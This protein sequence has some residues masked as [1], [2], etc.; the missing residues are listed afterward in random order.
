MARYP[1]LHKLHEMMQQKIYRYLGW[2]YENLAVSLY[3]A[4]NSVKFKKEF[5]SKVDK[6]RPVII[7]FADYQ[8]VDLALN[9]LKSTENVG[10]Q[11]LVTIALDEKLYKTLA[12][13]MLVNV[14]LFSCY[15]RSSGLGLVWK[16]R[17]IVIS[18]LLDEGYDIIHSDLDAIWLK[19]LIPEYLNTHSGLDLI[20]SQGTDFPIKALNQWGLVVCFGFFLIRSNERTKK[21]FKAI[22]CRTLLTGD[23]QQSL[24]ETLMQRNMI[25]DFETR[26]KAFLKNG[27]SFSFSDQIIQGRGDSIRVGI[28]PIKKF[29]R[30]MSYQEDPYVMHPLYIK[31]NKVRKFKED[32]LWFLK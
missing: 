26:Y 20:V 14:I 16:I 31:A 3:W 1:L 18:S 11:N 17:V 30:L 8:Y 21:L 24:N 13:R 29:V 7:A 12:E 23:D 27:R 10:V 19:K 25:W 2:I 22:V 5:S 6:G 9:W 4:S 15:N 28:L 32:G